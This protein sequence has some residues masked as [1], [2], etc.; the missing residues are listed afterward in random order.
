MV[1]PQAKSHQLI[2]QFGGYGWIECTNSNVGIG[3]QIT[4]VFVGVNDDLFGDNTGTF[5]FIISSIIA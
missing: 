3:D 2:V 1:Y 5:E 4:D